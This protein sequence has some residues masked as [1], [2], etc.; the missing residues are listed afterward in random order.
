VFFGVSVNLGYPSASFPFF[1]MISS[2]AISSWSQEYSESAPS[3]FH[4]TP[5]TH[6]MGI[7][8]SFVKPFGGGIWLVSFMRYDLGFFDEETCHLGS[9][10]NPLGAK[11]LPMSPV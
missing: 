3:A 7:P 6:R 1:E 11:V 9:A 2:Y 10:E 4:R 5:H 8:A